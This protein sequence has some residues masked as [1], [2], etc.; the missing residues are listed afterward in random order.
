MA[1]GMGASD[2]LS[3]VLKLN[4][5]CNY[6]DKLYRISAMAD[7]Q[8]R[9]SYPIRINGRHM[10]SWSDSDAILTKK[11]GSKSFDDVNVKDSNNL[12]FSTLRDY[13]S[14]YVS[15]TNSHMFELQ[16]IDG[17][18]NGKWMS[19][20]DFYNCMLINEN[21][22]NGRIP[23][24]N[25]SDVSTPAIHR[26]DAPDVPVPRT[27][28]GSYSVSESWN[29]RLCEAYLADGGQQTQTSTSAKLTRLCAYENP[30]TKEI[31]HT[32]EISCN[33]GT[34]LRSVSEY[35]EKVS[36]TKQ[37]DCYTRTLACG[38]VCIEIEI[39]DEEEEKTE[40]HRGD[41]VS[42][43]LFG[44]SIENKSDGTCVEIPE[45]SW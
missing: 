16:I 30:H 19:G 1:P 18:I 39:H 24:D 27:M 11:C 20:D 25:K 43:D 37:L 21:I 12:I 5:F 29:I 22:E 9:I 32:Y 4:C 40:W 26:N 42:Y 41:Y 23:T 6:H 2:K 33:D 13:V 44:I 15:S 34:I 7:K 3:N 31:Y 36:L 14:F 45:N 38:W 35:V 17:F 10:Q 8:S 28:D